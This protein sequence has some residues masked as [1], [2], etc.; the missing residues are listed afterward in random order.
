MATIEKY[1]TKAGATSWAVRYR[2]PDHR[3]TYKRGFATRRA[4]QAWANGVEVD[5]LTGSYIAP[6]MGRITVGELASDWLALKQHLAPSHY[7]TLESAWRIHVAP[8]WGKAA[9]AD[10]DLAG[11]EAWI[12]GMTRKGCGATT[13]VRAH[14][15][16]S[17]ILA[18]AAKKKSGSPPTRP[19]VPKPYRPRRVSD[20][21][22]SRPMM[23]TGWPRNPVNT[24]PWC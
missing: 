9:V 7:R 4:A 15:V 14:G 17:G 3:S 13:V 19:P 20:A 22:T 5:K 10:I 1:Q 8:V 21:S 6:S 16:L 24:E 18:Y 23:C 11:I 12:A 2:T